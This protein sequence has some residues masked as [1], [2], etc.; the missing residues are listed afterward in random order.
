MGVTLKRI[1]LTFYNLQLEIAD[2]K[3]TIRNQHESSNR[4]EGHKPDRTVFFVSLTKIKL[5]PFCKK[6]N[7]K[8][9]RWS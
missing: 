1:N 5:L 7:P 6:K 8:R 3:N 2:K 4:A 9:K